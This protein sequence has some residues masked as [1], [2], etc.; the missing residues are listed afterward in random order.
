MTARSDRA[1][2]LWRAGSDAE[3]A[4]DIEAAIAHYTASAK[5]G[6]T[7]AQSNLGT[8]LDDVVSPSRPAEAVYWYKRAVRCGY[9]GGAWNLAMHYRG[10]GVRRWYRHW[11]LVAARMGHEDAPH[12]L[13][14]LMKKGWMTSGPMPID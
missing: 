2:A 1:D 12:V 9:S 3:D 5:L 14:K 4:G 13:R 11:L 6:H 10:L 8:L 7:H